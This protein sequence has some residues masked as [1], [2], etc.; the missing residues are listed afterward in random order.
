MRPRH[1][2]RAVGPEPAALDP[3]RSPEA[4]GGEFIDL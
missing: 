3:I 1:Y 4:A 2:G